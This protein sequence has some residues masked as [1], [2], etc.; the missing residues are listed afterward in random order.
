MSRVG[1]PCGPP[2]AERSTKWKCHPDDMH[3][4]AA[5]RRRERHPDRIERWGDWIANY[6]I[7]DTTW[8]IHPARY[9]R[10]CSSTRTFAGARSTESH[11][12]AA[13]PDEDGKL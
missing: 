1:V 8:S 4:P 11:Q 6:V 2:D 5:R 3:A 9:R 13:R 12:L 7:H 10:I